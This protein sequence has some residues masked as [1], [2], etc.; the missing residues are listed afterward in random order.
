MNDADI[1]A[2]LNQREA[3]AAREMA[4]H[5]RVMRVMEG[6]ASVFVEQLMGT[7]VQT[8]PSAAQMAVANII[9]AAC[10]ATARRIAASPTILDRPTDPDKVRSVTAADLGS[11]VKQFW[12]RENQMDLRGYQIARWLLC[13]GEVPIT[14]LPDTARGIPVFEER[15]PLTCF[16]SETS[17]WNPAPANC[18]FRYTKALQEVRVA[19]PAAWKIDA[20]P[21]DQIEI[22][23][24]WDERE[25]RVIAKTRSWQKAQ[26][27]QLSQVD[28][29][30]G[31]PLFVIP[32]LITAGRRQGVF[33]QLLGLMGVKQRLQLLML[34]A[35]ERGVF[36]R[37]FIA[38]EVRGD[39]I[40]EGPDSTTQLEQGASVSTQTYN[41]SFQFMQ[42]IDRIERDIRIGGNFPAQLSGETPST[43]AT[44]RGNQML[45][46]ATIDEG[47]K[48][49][50][51]ILAESYR[52]L[53]DKAVLLD[54]AGYWSADAPKSIWVS[55]RGQSDVLTYTPAKLKPGVTRVEFG[56][57]SSADAAQVTVMLGQMSGMG[58]LSEDGA[59]ERHPFVDDPLL[60]KERI[61]L[62]HIDRSLLGS[63]EQQVAQG[64]LDPR[65]V[66]RIKKA[67]V[68]GKSLED[69]IEAAIPEAQAA[70]ELAGPAAPPGAMGPQQ[71]AAPPGKPGIQEIL[72]RLTSGGAA[73]SMMQSR[74][75]IGA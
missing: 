8:A 73:T 30:A 54:Q 36:P 39:I 15:D 26:F 56:L 24:Y 35:A 60:E 62:Q 65:A 3:A 44:G 19:Y 52:I 13:A 70:G 28:N 25:I 27:V 31:T 21:T 14:L 16:P 57:L 9:L 10:N 69:A 53:F 40:N 23:E 61:T 66:T 43:L 67:I 51:K 5:S 48:E 71:M 29:R 47:V 74:A 63:I 12:W 37:T 22:I 7:E 50:Q 20:N 55:Q 18:I 2:L 32:R 33:N 42:E 68:A 46:G 17:T 59:R 64:I 45:I 58:V 49:T 6:D 1:I 34:M 41:S 38:G 72:S 4:D 75:P 11:K